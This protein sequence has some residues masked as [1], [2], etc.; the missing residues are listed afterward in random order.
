L[1]AA[2]GISCEPD[3]VETANT[4]IDLPASVLACAL[5]SI[6][7]CPCPA[8]GIRDQPAGQVMVQTAHEVG[9][10]N[11]PGQELGGLSTAGIIGSA[12]GRAGRH[13][14]DGDRDGLPAPVPG[15]A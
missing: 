12:Q 1:P 6:T 5:Q 15:Q 2:V 4:A 13:S 9:E 7:A 8:P 10:N 11:H 14:R 3:V